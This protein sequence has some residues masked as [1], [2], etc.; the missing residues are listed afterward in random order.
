MLTA[1]SLGA[2][3]A[4]AGR[5]PLLAPGRRR[6]RCTPLARG[7]PGRADRVATPLRRRDTP[8]RARTRHLLI[9]GRKPLTCTNSI[10]QASVA[11]V[12][13]YGFA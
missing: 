13:P 12:T 6:A 4:F 11:A 8:R 7:D 1:L 3:A 9:P 10:L 2:D 5:A